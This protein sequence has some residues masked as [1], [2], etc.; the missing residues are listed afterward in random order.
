MEYTLTNGVY[1]LDTISLVYVVDNSFPNVSQN[2]IGQKSVS[3]SGLDLFSANTEN[4]YKCISLSTVDL[5]DKASLQLKNYQAEPFIKDPKTND[6]DTGKFL[7]LLIRV[8]GLFFNLT[9]FSFQ[10]QSNVRLIFQIR[11]NWYLSL[12]AQHWLF[13]LFL[14]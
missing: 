12:L 9:K 11:A 6:F 13:L 1:Q 3:K 7:F 4:S 5:S 8:R 14:F 10:K 2:E